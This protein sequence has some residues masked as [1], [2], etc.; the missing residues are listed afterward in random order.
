MEKIKVNICNGTTCFVM[1]ASKFQEAENLIPEKLKKYVDVRLQSCLDLCK[2]NEYTKSPYIKVDDEV[3]SE[4]TVEK[5][6]DVI[7]RKINE[8]NQGDSNV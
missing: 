6:L 4:A 3:I 2:N 8:I 7:Q 1:G 5:L